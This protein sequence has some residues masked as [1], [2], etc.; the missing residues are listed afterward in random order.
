MVLVGKWTCYQL[1]PS[2]TSKQSVCKL[3]Q[4]PQAFCIALRTNELWNVCGHQLFVLFWKAKSLQC[5]NVGPLQVLVSISCFTWVGCNCPHRQVYVRQTKKYPCAIKIPLVWP[6][7]SQ[8]SLP[9]PRPS[10]LS[11]SQLWIVSEHDLPC[12]QAVRLHTRSDQNLKGK[13]PEEKNIL[14]QSLT[15]TCYQNCAREFHCNSGL[16]TSTW[17]SKMLHG[18]KTWLEPS[19]NPEPQFNRIIQPPFYSDILKHIMQL[20]WNRAVTSDRLWAKGRSWGHPRLLSR[21]SLHSWQ[22]FKNFCLFTGSLTVTTPTSAKQSFLQ[23]HG[24]SSHLFQ[25]F[26]NDPIQIFGRKKQA[27][28]WWKFIVV[29]SL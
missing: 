10:N 26:L 20:S 18:V 14:S 15:S 27:E 21:K 5:V 3:K 25:P 6:P 16:L 29:H 1:A 17:L 7:G 22:F 4:L 8:S 24:G 2:R 9:I 13:L 12:F 23:L 11:F 28:S 19:H